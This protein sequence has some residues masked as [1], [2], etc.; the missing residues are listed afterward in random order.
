MTNPNEMSPRELREWAKG[1]TSFG[2]YGSAVDHER[3]KQPVNP[4]SRGRCWCC[5]RR[6]THLGMANGV[7]LITGCEILVTRWV[8]HG[9]GVT[10]SKRPSEKQ[11]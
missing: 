9:P 1:N 8:K 2:Q 4:K 11:P 6:A 3:Y 5:K 10:V 7:A